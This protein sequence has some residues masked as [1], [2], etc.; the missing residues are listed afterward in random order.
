MTRA[1]GTEFVPIF[2]RFIVCS[3]NPV[4]GLYAIA[5]AFVAINWPEKSA[6]T[7]LVLAVLFARFV[8]RTPKALTDVEKFKLP[9]F[10]AC[11]RRL[12]VLTAPLV[13]VP[14]LKVRLPRSE[15]HTS[16]LQSP[17]Y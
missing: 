15:E 13:R 1:D 6:M 5:E 17:M 2:A 12:K 8:S 10:V 3:I 4:C 16:E 14:R 9:A 11:T 7:M